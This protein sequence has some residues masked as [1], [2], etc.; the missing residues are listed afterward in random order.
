VLPVVDF[1]LTELD[2]AGINPRVAEQLGLPVDST[3]TRAYSSSVS[4][5]RDFARSAR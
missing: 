3:R 2:D 4:A 1:S 5:L